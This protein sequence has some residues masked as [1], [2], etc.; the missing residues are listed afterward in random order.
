M[1]RRCHFVIVGLTLA[2]CT[3][4]ADLGGA[5]GPRTLSGG[6]RSTAPP[7][8]GDG[9]IRLVAGGLERGPRNC[10]GAGLCVTGGIVP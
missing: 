10:N 5:S 2:A 9:G 6:I 3:E 1:K 7:P 4:N 8:P